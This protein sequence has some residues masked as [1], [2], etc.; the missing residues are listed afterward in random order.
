MVGDVAHRVDVFLGWAGRDQHVFAGQC[1]VLE[2]FGGA[3]RQ[4]VCLK[5]SAQADVAAG[6]AARSGA[7]NLKVAAL[8]QL[9]VCLGRGVAPHG[10]V[11]G[12]GQ[13]DGRVCRQHQ[14]RQQIIGDALG[15]ARDQVGGGRGDQNQVC[16][17]G[18]FDMAHGCLG[19]RVE[20]VHVHGVP[21]QGLHGQW[22]D[23]FTAATGHDHA[24]FGTVLKEPANQFGALVGG[25]AAAD[26]ENDAFPIQ[27]L[28]RPCL[29]V[30][31]LH[32]GDDAWEV[33]SSPENDGLR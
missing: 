26:A 15:Q 9:Q 21:G 12:R 20:Q 32:S 19:S 1:L 18:Q 17:L 16:P 23:E 14:S 30:Q 27:P 22:G 11:H 2:T 24:H 8:Q 25:N 10:L 28:H 31:C 33:R 7:K 5:H 4:V 29:F 3:L 6:L 13:G